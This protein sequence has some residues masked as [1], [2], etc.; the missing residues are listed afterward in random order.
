MISL[1]IFFDISRGAELVHYL[2]EEGKSL[3]LYFTLI[4][5]LWSTAKCAPPF[6]FPQEDRK[7]GVG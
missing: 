5:T 2:N 1:F 3:C 6:I 4:I 7:Q